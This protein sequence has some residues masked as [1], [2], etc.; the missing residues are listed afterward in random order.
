MN[1][2]DYKDVDVNNKIV[3]MLRGKPADFPSEEGAHYVSRNQRRA[4]AVK[5]GA[6]GMISLQTPQEEARY[7]Y[8]R[9]VKTIA[10]PAMNWLNEQQQP[11]DYFPQLKARALLSVDAAS[12]LLAN[13]NYNY[14]QL[15]ELAKANKPLPKFKLEGK[16]AVKSRSLHKSV[17]SH[18]VVAM[19]EGTDPALRDQVI[20]YS[21]HL[22]HI[23]TSHT[24]HQTDDQATHAENDIDIVNNGAL[25]NASGVAIM[26]ETARLFAENPPKRSILF[27]AVTGEEKG[28][29]G[30]DFFARNPTVDIDNIVANINLDMPLILY[31]IGDVIAFGAQHSTMG[32]FVQQAAERVGLQLSPDPMPEENIFVRSDHYSFVKQGVPS[33]FL[34]PGFKSLDESVDG[35][36]IFKEFFAEHY[37]QETDESTLPINYQSGAIFTQVNYLIGDNIANSDQLPRWHENNFFGELYKRK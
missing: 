9:I 2:D 26:L 14:E 19:I 23:G 25:D 13:A 31:P 6:V 30:S 5:H 33:V 3:V 27:V 18:N 29:L 10:T 17:V 24:A 35:G 28:L 7:S 36:K 1:Y 8:Q 15:I 32:Q 37:H 22:D 16:L 12:K 34:M 11:N 20:V 21:A 4:A